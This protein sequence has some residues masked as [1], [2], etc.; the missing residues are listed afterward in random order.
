MTGSLPGDGRDRTRQAVAALAEPRE[1]ERRRGA[2]RVRLRPAVRQAERPLRRRPPAGIAGG[3]VVE[4]VDLP[5]RRGTREREHVARARPAARGEA[6]LSLL[7]GGLAAVLRAR[8]GRDGREDGIAGDLGQPVPAR[9]A[10]RGA[11]AAAREKRDGRE[12][13]C[14]GAEPHLPKSKYARWYVPSAS[15]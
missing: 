6:A 1:D 10:A 4:A 9:V 8:S 15:L 7:R 14:E 13:S 5:G 3:A 11:P 2:V 12:G